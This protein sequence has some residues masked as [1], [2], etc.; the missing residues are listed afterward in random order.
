M[1]IE[2]AVE[3]IKAKAGE[4]EM[5]ANRR[6]ECGDLIEAGKHAG[7]KEGLE[8]ALGLLVDEGVVTA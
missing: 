3:R 1:G 5:R 2:I 7:R 6:R 4:E 8:S